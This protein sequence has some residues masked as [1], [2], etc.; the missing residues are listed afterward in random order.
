MA[1]G[2]PATA[3]LL[4]DTT[5]ERSVDIC[6]CIVIWIACLKM[7]DGL[8]ASEFWWEDCVGSHSWSCYRTLLLRR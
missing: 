1:Q 6:M 4:R 3:A 5:K 2:F 7:Y 8:V